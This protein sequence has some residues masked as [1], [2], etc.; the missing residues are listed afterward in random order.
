MDAMRIAVVIGLH[1]VKERN[2]AFGA[3]PVLS[4]PFA[5]QVGPIDSG[6]RLVYNL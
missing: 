2:L 1:R 5:A 4:R 3:A 6:E